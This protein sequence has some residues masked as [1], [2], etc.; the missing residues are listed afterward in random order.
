MDSLRFA[1]YKGKTGKY[2]AAQFNTQLPHF[3][4]GKEY[5]D[6]E[7]L[8]GPEPWKAYELVDDSSS[9]KKRKRLKDGWKQREGAVFLEITSPSGNNEYDWNQ[10]VILALSIQDLGQ[11][12]YFLTTGKDPR[13]LSTPELK[14]VHDPHA[15]TVRAKKV[16]KS[17]KLHT[18]DKGIQG[19]CILSVYEK[20][21]QQAK[22]H[23]VPL[24]GPEVLVL[25]TLITSVMPKLLAW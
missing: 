6:F 5:K 24:S 13:D 7:G 9:S 20:E 17:L 4:K 16:I 1:V 19:G 14:I 8:I 12:L 2:G 15:Q 18:G 21:G 25:K 23:Q 22:S 10:K 3:F 11:V